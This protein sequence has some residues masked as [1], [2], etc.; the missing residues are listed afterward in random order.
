M[1]DCIEE[2]VLQS[3][4][5]DELSPE[6]ADDVAAH[7]NA[8]QTCAEALSEAI[9]E[10]TVFTKAF[11]PQ[12]TLD[13]PTARLR[14]RIDEGI[15]QLNRPR[16]I[17]EQKQGSSLSGWL[18]SF[19]GLFKVSPE[20]ALG[21]ASLIAV[22]AF[23]AIFATIQLRRAVSND[24]PTLVADN[25]KSAR[26]NAGVKESPSPTPEVNNV[27]D[28][29][30]KGGNNPSEKPKPKKQVKPVLVPEPN[31]LPQDELAKALPGEQNYLKAID[32]LTVEI[33][34]SGETTMKPS[35][36]AEYERNLA[37]VD[38]AIDSTRRVARLHRNDPDA[39]EFLYSSYRSKLELLGAVA[40]QVRPTVAVR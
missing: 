27:N 33:Q 24:A 13:V 26:T 8:C 28:Q 21:F 6:M 30:V 40:E 14:E 37:I 11:E 23:A 36:R 34:A 19:A 3:Y 16:E 25:N 1:R 38:H 39:A 18:A 31:Q 9:H 15:A 5:D 20:R 22:V 10:T 32:S 17:L 12:M 35:L 29:S 4:I 7:L 2:G